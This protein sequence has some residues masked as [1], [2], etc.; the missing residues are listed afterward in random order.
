M[1]ALDESYVNAAAPNADAAKNGRALMLKKQFLNCHISADQT[2]LFGQCQGSGKVPYDCSC[3]FLKPESPIH[4]CSCPSRQFPCKHCIGLMYIYLQNAGAFTVAA[5]P[6]ALQAKREKAEVRAEKK[7]EESAKPK[8]VNKSALTKKIH[9]QLEGI[10]LLEQMT[11]NLVRIGIGN[12]NVKSIHEIE[13]RAKQLGDAYLPGAQAALRSYTA[14]FESENGNFDDSISASSREVIYSNAF[15]QLAR[16]NAMVKQGRSYLEKRLADPELK[17][18]TDSSIAAWLGHAWQLTELGDAG[19]VQ[20]NVELMQ[21]AF[22][23]H[24]DA[25]RLEIVDT[26]IW[27]ELQSGNVYTT[28]NYRPYHAVKFI[29]EEDSFFQIAQIDQLY[30]YPG[31]LNQR[32]RWQAAKSRA[33]DPKDFAAIHE[34]AEADFAAFTKLIK[35]NLKGPLSEKQPVCL[36]RFKQI[37][38]VNEQY[39]IEDANGNRITLTDRGIREEPRSLHLLPYLPAESLYNQTLAGR[40]RHDLD[41]RRLEL[42][43]LAIITQHE[44]IRLTL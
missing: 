17:P 23:T 40:F 41:S 39:V 36:L 37:G 28:K 10:K 33:V 24:D 15:D 22:N 1:L 16:L 30:I 8:K 32:I 43:P 7:K 3:D 26:G 6:E 29:K 35:N 31:D 25:A 5:V 12:M 34:R 42:T 18:E 2:L 13:D 27:V 20:N 11:Q 21:I 38:K 19:L 14:L 9:A 4:R 44:I